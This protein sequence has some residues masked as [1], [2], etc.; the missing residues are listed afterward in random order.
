MSARALAGAAAAL[1]AIVAA[2]P[3]PRTEEPATP[4]AAADTSFAGLVASLSEPGGYFDTDNLISNESSY[5]HAANA[6]DV[7]ARQGGAYIGVG[8]DQN[9]SYIGIVRPRVAF[10]IDIRRDNLLQHLFFKAVFA[11]TGDR[12]AYLCL[13]LARS[14]GETEGGEATDAP[15]EALLAIVDSAGSPP[16]ALERARS[17]IEPTLRSF[18]VPLDDADMAT[19]RSIHQRFADAGLELRFASHGRAPRP[20]YPTLRRLLLETDRTGRPRSYLADPTAF[21]HVRRMQ[22]D[23]RIIPVVGDLAGDHAL[24]A[25][26]AEIRRRG[27][28]LTAFYASNVEDYLIRDGSFADYLD[29]VRSLPDDGRALIIRSFFHNRTTHPHAVP[30]YA[31]TQVVQRIAAMLDDERA[32]PH[33]SYFD[34]ATRNTLTPRP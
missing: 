10:L 7:F 31:S 18:G 8:P 19:I 20:W 34:L 13:L 26:G 28:V 29:N 11:Q 9:F 12:L 16:A 2:W 3:R 21:D 33:R 15:I 30:G 6:L 14:C 22:H 24:R 32:S 1:L 4:P 5:L 25:I 23:D 27:L 17:R